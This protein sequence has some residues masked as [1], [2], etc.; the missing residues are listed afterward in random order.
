[1]KGSDVAMNDGLQFMSEGTRRI[2]DS[3]ECPAWKPDLN[4]GRRSMADTNSITWLATRRSRS[5]DRTGKLEID[6]YELTYSASRPG[7]FTTGVL[8]ACL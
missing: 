1:M 3:V 6:R 5:I 8:S 4:D 2:A 7:F